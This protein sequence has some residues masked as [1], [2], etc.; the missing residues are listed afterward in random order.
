MLKD[1][2]FREKPN[3]FNELLYKNKLLI[4]KNIKFEYPE[5][6]IFSRQFGNLEVAYPVQ[7]QPAGH[8]YIRIQSNVGKG[9]LDYG[10]LYWHTDGSWQKIPTKATLLLCIEAPKWGGETSFVDMCCAYKDLPNKVKQRIKKLKGF[11]PC[12]EIHIKEMEELGL[13]LS[14]AKEKELQDVFHPLVK[15]HPVTG[16][17][18]LY[19]NQ[20]WLKR[21][22][23]LPEKESKD[24][25]DY[26]YEFSS[27]EFRIYAH[28][29]EVGDL[30]VWDD[31]TIMHKGVRPSPEYPK[32]TWRITIQG[33]KN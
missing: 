33:E 17:K 32:I 21:I 1:S 12:K 2:Y 29:W 25:L 28:T 31:F 6:E 11:Y 4:F 24:L 13:Q 3:F 14:E 19:L 18:A 27:Q 15:V 9:G 30:L 8:P 5:F 20:L 16:E 23:G 7:Y 26:L 10:G 22:E